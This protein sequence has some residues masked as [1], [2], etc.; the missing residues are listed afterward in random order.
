[1]SS[2]LGGSS[3]ALGPLRSPSRG[4]ET[5]L[6]AFFGSWVALEEAADF[7]VFALLGDELDHGA[8]DA[9]A[10][11]LCLRLE[12][13]TA[14]MRRDCVGRSEE[15]ERRK[16]HLDHNVE[17]EIFVGH[18][19]IH[20][21]GGSFRLRETYA[22]GRG[23]PAADCFY[24][25]CFF[26]HKNYS[27]TTKFLRRGVCIVLRGSMRATARRRASPLPLRAV[28]DARLSRRNPPGN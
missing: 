20:Q 27:V 7:E 18:F 11:R 16:C 26:C 9:E 4:F 19:S 10:H 1:M 23:L 2:T 6:F 15:R 14:H 8:G 3:L 5:K 28:S 17:R 22:G 21:H 25:S 13:P 12:S 24:I